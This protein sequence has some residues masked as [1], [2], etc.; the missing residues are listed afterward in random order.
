MSE[1]SVRGYRLSP[2]QRHVWRLQ[3]QEKSRWRYET[4][5]EIRIQGEVDL[6]RLKVSLSRIIEKNEILRST[7]VSVPG[8]AVPLQGVHATAEPFWS[9]YDLRGIGESEKQDALEQVNLEA[10]KRV[11]NWKSGPLLAVQVIRLEDNECRI[12]IQLPALYSDAAGLKNLIRAWKQTYEQSGV[13]NQAEGIS[14]EDFQYAAVAEWLNGNLEDSSAETGQ[15]FWRQQQAIA[16]ARVKLPWTKTAPESSIE[17][18]RAKGRVTVGVGDAVKRNLW[19]KA[20][21]Q[22]VSVGAW[23]EACWRVLLWRLTGEK[24]IAMALMGDGRGAE[25]LCGVIGLLAR[26]VP[27]TVELDAGMK[28]DDL[29]HKISQAQKESR[30]WQEYFSFAESSGENHGRTGIFVE[31]VQDDAEIHSVDGSEG[32]KEQWVL[33]QVES[34]VD[35]YEWKL[36]CRQKGQACEFELFYDNQLWAK[37][38]AE[39]MAAQLE[40][41]LESAAKNI[42]MTVEEMEV[43]GTEERSQLVNKFNNTRVDWGATSK[44][45]HQFFEE[46]VERAGERIAVTFGEEQITYKQLNQQ[47]NQWAHYL[48][49]QGVGPDVLVGVLLERSVE[50]VVTLLGILKAGGAY[51][52]LDPAYPS[53]R[54]QYMIADSGTPL[55][56][57]RADLAK[58]IDSAKVRVLCLD[59]EKRTLGAQQESN[60]CVNNHADSLAYVLYTSGSTGKPKAVMISHAAITNHM[61]WLV[62]EY[63]IQASDS[64]IQKTAY[65][66]DA[67]VWEFF[68]PLMTGATLVVAPP[69]IQHDPAQLMS[70]VAEKKVT[71]LQA[72]PTLL[73]SLVE[74]GLLAHGT[75]LRLIFSG[76]ERLGQELQDAV[77]NTLD[78]E[79][80]N[81]YGPTEVCIDAV[82]QRCHS[83]ESVGIGRPIANIRAYVLDG[84][85][86]LLPLGAVGELYLAGAGLARGYWQRSPETA[87]KFLP[88]PFAV[89]GGER[90]YRTG[91][92]VRYR[93]GGSL[94]YI[95]RTDHQIKIRGFRVELGEIE[96]S[97][98]CHDAVKRC[99]V[100]Q[101]GGNPQESYLAAYLEIPQKNVDIDEIRAFARQLLPDYMVPAIW[102]VL[103]E[104]PCL[105]NG[106]I[107]RSA[108]PAPEA[109]A[110]K[111]SRQ[112]VPPQN[113]LEHTMVGLWQEVLVRQDVGTQDNFFDLGGHSL[114]AI[115]LHMK[116]KQIGIS[117]NIL[118]L[119]IYPTIAALAGFVGGQQVASNAEVFSEKANDRK[120]RLQH[121]RGAQEK[122]H[123]QILVEH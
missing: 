80:V 9:E 71:V 114:K 117:I 13:A 16:P 84:G 111:S 21:E 15:Q 63:S 36:M 85:L 55:V 86:R 58:D 98:V 79:L 97:L 46:Q 27:I 64:I 112:P 77:L 19:L 3:E 100:V 120:R 56:I 74:S 23:A 50:L 90:L 47:S 57:S 101:A 2:Q 88:N 26:Y 92:L 5:G 60:P 53:E 116:L 43:V 31:E 102:V 28:F 61:C 66:F 104:L 105:P 65:S 4:R 7:F 109:A 121:Q 40:I 20:C 32:K 48:S 119:F 122:A 6:K 81:L 75:C 99:A 76:G 118:D 8:L 39:R 52:P 87:E 70:I 44:L 25:E 115:K 11:W 18:L 83:L 62:Q 95:G 67:S 69:G 54:L 1:S 17:G 91:D 38:D 113:D 123:R 10:D 12:K 93:P 72:V 24:R 94:E 41:A 108:L 14:G 107:N 37:A 106:K 68:A 22:G 89:E 73:A 42:H 110:I 29:L 82:Y 49:Q 45:L 96:A 78:V 35:R 30:E 59:E 103:Q 33:D 34:E 51:L